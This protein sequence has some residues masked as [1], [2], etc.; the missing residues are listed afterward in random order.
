MLRTILKNYLRSYGYS[1]SNEPYTSIQLKSRLKATTKTN[2]KSKRIVSRVLIELICLFGEY[3]QGDF[4]FHQNGCSE[5]MFSVSVGSFFNM[6]ISNTQHVVRSIVCASINFQLPYCR[7]TFME[8]ES[9]GRYSVW[10]L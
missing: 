10:N 8:S 3:C 4:Q 7:T 1:T 9:I 5:T 2:T 6:R